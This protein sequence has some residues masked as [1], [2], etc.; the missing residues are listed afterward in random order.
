MINLD[1]CNYEKMTDRE[2]GFN[3]CGRNASCGTVVHQVS[4]A[5]VVANK[6]GVELRKITLTTKVH[7]EIYIDGSFLYRYHNEKTAKSMWKDF[8]G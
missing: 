8:A 5:E 2:A 4:V 3:T 1:T 6:N 7:F